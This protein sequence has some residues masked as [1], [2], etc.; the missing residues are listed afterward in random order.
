M[1]NLSFVLKVR[2]SFVSETHMLSCTANR[3]L[4]CNQCDWLSFIVILWVYL[5]TSCVKQV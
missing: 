5:Q 1:S 3:A 2:M 4:L